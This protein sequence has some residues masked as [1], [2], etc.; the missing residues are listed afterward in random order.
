MKK[1]YYDKLAIGLSALCTLHCLALPLLILILPSISATFL[2]DESIHLIMA[3]LVLPVSG[4]ALFLG[5]QQHHNHSVFL[6]GIFGLVILFFS[7]LLGHELLGE[8]IEKLLT[9]L[10][11]CL[12]CYAHFLNYKYCQ[13]NEDCGCHDRLNLG[14]FNDLEKVNDEI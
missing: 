1:I 7:I 11:S 3:F 8:I 2:V 6:L 14:G 9:V 5:L 13:S 12:V 10:A 4:F